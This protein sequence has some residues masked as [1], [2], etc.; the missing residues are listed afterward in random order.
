MSEP[1]YSDL[2]KDL[3]TN[4]EFCNKIS[5]ILHEIELADKAGN[6]EAVRQHVQ[7]LL[8]ACNFN[9]SLLVPYFFPRFPE[10]EPMTLWTRPHSFSMMGLTL[11]GSLTVQASR[12]IGKCVDGAT[13]LIT[14]KSGENKDC[15]VTIKDLFLQSKE[16]VHPRGKGVKCSE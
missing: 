11:L 6:M 4:P 15:T 5:K 9:A 16:A 13:K 1:V 7:D 12:Q 3:T 14:R 10:F 2:Y 8:I